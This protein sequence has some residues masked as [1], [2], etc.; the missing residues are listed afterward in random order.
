MIVA[1][2]GICSGLGTA[3]LPKLQ[4]ETSIEKI[5]GID[6]AEY[7][8]DSK[9]IE[10]YK[11][12]VRDKAGIKRALYKVDVIIHLAFI[13]IPKKLP[14]LQE[15]YDINVNGSKNVFSVAAKKGVSKIIYLSSQS[16]YG[17]VKECPRIVKEE[18]PRLGIKTTNFYYSH[19]KALVEE[20][21]DQFKQNYPHIAVIRLRPPIITGPHFMENLGLFKM[22]GK[23]FVIHP[24]H[25]KNRFALQLIHENDLTDIMIK[26]IK[27]DIRGAYN[28]GGRILPDFRILYDKYGV[29]SIPLPTFLLNLV[30]PLGRIWPK[31]SWLQALK[32]NSLL[33]TEKIERELGW[34]AKYSTKQCIE[35]L[36][37]MDN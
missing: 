23:R 35:E 8:G 9:K 16:V 11:V 2:T 19:T 32:Y 33:N 27:K 3:L 7:K 17:H 18:A 24:F 12:D 1:V 25:R 4:Q 28:V 36:N 21:L 22:A 20:F 30:I 13:V 37:K 31:L 10:Y 14:S 29:L 26:V 6:L 5:I 15:I 34:K